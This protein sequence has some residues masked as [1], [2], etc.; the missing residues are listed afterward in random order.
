G[1]GGTVNLNSAIG[2][3]TISGTITVSS[4]DPVPTSTPVP[5]RVSSSGGNVNVTSGKST[6]TGITV[7]N[8]SQILA[9]LNSAAAGPGGKITFVIN[10]AD[11]NFNGKAQADRGVIDIDTAG[12]N[13]ANP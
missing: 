3:V 6:G 9:L 1:A 11:I 4:N 12:G 13:P 2:Q 8:S 7:A 10:G 5:V